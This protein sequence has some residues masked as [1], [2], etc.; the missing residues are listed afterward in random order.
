MSPGG[1]DCLPGGPVGGQQ[2]PV[3]ATVVWTEAGSGL[4]G[5]L[6][7]SFT[8]RHSLS[9]RNETKRKRD[10]PRMPKGALS[11][12]VHSWAGFARPPGLPAPPRPCSQAG[13]SPGS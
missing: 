1:S 3:G 12:G 5:S 4:Q 2:E 9:Q 11:P 10:K 6:R 8:R 13:A 7:V